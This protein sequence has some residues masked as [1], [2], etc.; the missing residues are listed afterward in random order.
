MSIHNKDASSFAK[1]DF[2][3]YL[4]RDNPMKSSQEFASGLETYDG[5]QIHIKENSLRNP[6]HAQDKS[7][8]PRAH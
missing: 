3:F 4:L 1:G 2:R 5:M 8:P 7:Y 6:F